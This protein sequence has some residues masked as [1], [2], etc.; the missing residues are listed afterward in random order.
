MSRRSRGAQATALLRA[1]GFGVSA[2]AGTLQTALEAGTVVVL[3][4]MGTAIERARETQA[5]ADAHPD[6][7]V[8]VAMPTDGGRLRCA[9]L[10]PGAAGIVLEDDLA[11]ALAPTVRRW[12]PATGRAELVR[13][14][15]APRA[16]SFREKQ[17][18]G[19][20]VLGYTNRQIADKLFLAEIGTVKTHLSSAFAKLDARS[21][22]EATARILDPE[23]GYGV[24]FL[25]PGNGAPTPAA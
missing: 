12:P 13:R 9:R 25:T 22:A 17:M 5:L 7:H 1:A 24:G 20:V 14:Q 16:L 10:R 18:L 19:L 15:I 3:L 2:T 6:C 8:V 21:R 4:A 23:S 11:R